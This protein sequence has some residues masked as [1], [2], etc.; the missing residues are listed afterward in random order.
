MLRVVKCYV[1]EC[2]VCQTS[3]SSHESSLRPLY[4]IP[5]EES[6]HTLSLDFITG[7]PVSQRKDALFTVTDKF[8]KA[9]HLIPCNKDTNIIETAKLY[10]KYCYPIFSLPF[11][12]IS[13]R[14]ARFTSR[15]WTSLMHLLG[16]NQGMTAAFH[17]S[18]DGQA[19]KTNQIMEIGLR[20]FLDGNLTK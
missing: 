7:L 15:F 13:D 11:K 5:A 10:L 8:T 6:C 19:E 16:V 3:K 17:P 18:A 12:L 4:P 14:D 1:N 2:A 20:C 9:M